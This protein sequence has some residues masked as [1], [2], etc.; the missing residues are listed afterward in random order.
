M[1]DKLTSVNIAFVHIPKTAGLS[2]VDA[3]VRKLGEAR[4]AAY[5]ETIGDDDF[6]TK[7]FVAGHVRLKNVTLKARRFTF[8][9]DP[10][11]QLASHLLWIDHYNM[12]QYEREAVLFCPSVRA[13]FEALRHVDLSVAGEINRYLLERPYNSGILLGNAQSKILALASDELLPVGDVDLA[14]RAIAALSRLEFIGITE[15]LATD[16]ADLFRLLCLSGEPEVKHLNA[17]PA[18]R[19][20]DLAVPAIR[21]ALEAHVGADLRL[22]EAASNM[23]ERRLR[24]V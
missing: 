2:I 13:D 10:I 11:S 8:L 6:L 9:R 4:C 1:V 3:F 14:Q 12:A 18:A 15:H 17:S 5:S 16:L 24:A 19:R 21:R 20:I 7:T 23:R 22:W